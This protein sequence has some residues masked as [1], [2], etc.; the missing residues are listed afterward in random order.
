M[1]CMKCQK[2]ISS[3]KAS[4]PDGSGRGYVC[5]ECNATKRG[6]LT[7]PLG[8]KAGGRGHLPYLVCGN[9]TP[10]PATE[11]NVVEYKVRKVGVTVAYRGQKVGVDVLECPKCGHQILR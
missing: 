9:C 7:E 6:D 11:E 4:D 10:H 2:V 5:P 1:R 8:G 3:S